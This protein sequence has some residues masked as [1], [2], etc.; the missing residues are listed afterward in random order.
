MNSN[1]QNAAYNASLIDDKLIN[2]F[3]KQFVNKIAAIIG[4]C[5]WISLVLSA[6]RYCKQHEDMIRADNL[7]SSIADKEY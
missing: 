2:V 6:M 1:C 7:A 5:E 3:V 4:E